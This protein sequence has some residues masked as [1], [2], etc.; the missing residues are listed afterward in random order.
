MIKVIL[1]E[2]SVVLIFYAAFIANFLF[3][4]LIY[5]VHCNKK[6]DDLGYCGSFCNIIVTRP[7]PNEAR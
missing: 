6:N 2:Y 1:P 5:L 4:K 3:L 7:L